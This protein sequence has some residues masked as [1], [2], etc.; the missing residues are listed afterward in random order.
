MAAEKDFSD[1]HSR[2]TGVVADTIANLTTVRTQSAEDREEAHVSGLV[3]ESVDRDLRAR[4][5]LRRDA[6]ADGVR[7]RRLQLGGGRRRRAA[8]PPPRRHGGSGLPDPLLRHRSSAQPGGV[9]RAHPA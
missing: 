3:D 8:R 4:A 7:P 5:R 1:A 2:A 9:L 6:A